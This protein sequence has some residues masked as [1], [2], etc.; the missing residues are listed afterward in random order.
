MG[1]AAGPTP[2]INGGTHLT[3]DHNLTMQAVG[4][5]A[6]GRASEESEESEERN[7]ETEKRA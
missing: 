1:V 7:V 5:K 4:A 6:S 2:Q 3:F